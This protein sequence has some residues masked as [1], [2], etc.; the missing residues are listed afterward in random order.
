MKALGILADLVQ[1]TR[2]TAIM[3]EVAVPS[4]GIN[5]QEVRV[6]NPLLRVSFS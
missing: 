1:T 4:F 6:V 5:V 3:N 2:R